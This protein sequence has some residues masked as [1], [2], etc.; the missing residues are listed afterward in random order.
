[1]SD[2]KKNTLYFWYD[3]GT[4]RF[5]TFADKTVWDLM[6]GPYVMKLK[7]EGFP[8]VYY[9]GL[10]DGVWQ[11]LKATGRVSIGLYQYVEA[12]LGLL[13]QYKKEFGDIK[14]KTWHDLKVELEEVKRL[15]PD[16][17]EVRRTKTVSSLPD[18]NPVMVAD[19]RN[20]KFQ[21]MLR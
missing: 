1:M 13:T 4:M 5:T 12:C 18:E 17:V 15:L 7:I 3:N 11:Y 2:D 10:D 21:S 6:N 14:E 16:K 9:A 8:A 19:D 20:A